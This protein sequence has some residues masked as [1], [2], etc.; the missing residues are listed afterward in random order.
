MDMPNMPR[1]TPR[2]S[3]DFLIVTQVVL[4][5]EIFTEWAWYLFFVVRYWLE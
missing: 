2:Y 5:L 3:M 4:L 1:L